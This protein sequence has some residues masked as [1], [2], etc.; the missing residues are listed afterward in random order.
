M[1]TGTLLILIAGATT[2]IAPGAISAIQI[3]WRHSNG[4]TISGGDLSWIEHELDIEPLACTV[5]VDKEILLHINKPAPPLFKHTQAPSH[6]RTLANQSE[7]LRRDRT[8]SATSDAGQFYS[9]K[10]TTVF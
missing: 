7:R 4:S 5:P 3:G 9:I 8:V 2:S 10:F 1:K 6:P